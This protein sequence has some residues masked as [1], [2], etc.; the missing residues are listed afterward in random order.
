MPFVATGPL[1]R[2]G[3]VRKCGKELQAQRIPLIMWTDIVSRDAHL[4]DGFIEVAIVLLR[5]S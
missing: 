2:E 3:K 5:I 1:H 4:K